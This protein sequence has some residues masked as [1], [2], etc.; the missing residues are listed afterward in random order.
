MNNEISNYTL[1]FLVIIG[2]II[3]I[4]V[5]DFLYR[6][7]Y[8]KNYLLE[9]D[10]NNKFCGLEIIKLSIPNEYITK[11]K[12]LSIKEGTRVEIPG[13]HQK[14]ISYEILIKEL[15]DLEKYYH[16]CSKIVSKYIGTKVKPLHRNMKTR[17]SLV[18]YEKEGDYID[19]HFDTNHYDGRFFTLLI[20]ITSE[21][22]CGNYQYRNKN[23][24]DVDV[25]IEKDQAIL[26]EGDKVFHRGKKLC[27]K[28]RRIILSITFVTS[29]NLNYWN[30]IMLKMKEFGIFGK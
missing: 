3:I 24:E 29:N 7:L 17:M 19:W 15:P 21:A 20:P 2:I 4:F 25:E 8:Y 9:C 27:D 6:T 13:K 23:E 11:L 5:Y 12:E 1:L 18:V 30:Y 10:P 14:N 28:Q 26:F 16:K 22:T